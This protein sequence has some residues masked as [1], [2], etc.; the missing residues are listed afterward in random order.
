MHVFNQFRSNTSVGSLLI[1]G[2][3]VLGRCFKL[4]TKDPFRSIM[5]IIHIIGRIFIRENENHP[6]W[7]GKKEK[8]NRRSLHNIRIEKVRKGRFLWTKLTCLVVIAL[9]GRSLCSKTTPSLLYCPSPLHCPIPS[10]TIHIGPPL[11]L[12]LSNNVTSLQLLP[13][14]THLPSL[15]LIVSSTPLVYD[16]THKRTILIFLP[17]LASERKPH[18]W[19]PFSGSHHQ[20]TCL[21]VS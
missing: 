9:F 6:F 5:Q 3:F 21:L 15:W 11:S 20:N 10:F 8:E 19:V 2:F 16:H 7:K 14:L 13:A 18:M 17:C 1:H 4:I 12:S